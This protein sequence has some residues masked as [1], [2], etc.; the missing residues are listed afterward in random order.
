MPIH[1]S[2]TQRRYARAASCIGPLLVT[3]LFAALANQA[4]AQIRPVDLGTLGGTYST[5][6]RV[7]AGGHVVGNSTTAGDVAAH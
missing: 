1:Q 3:F 7:N 4:A 6:V 5:A 2:S